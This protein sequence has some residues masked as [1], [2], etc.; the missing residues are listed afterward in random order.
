MQF[1]VNTGIEE[2][3]ILWVSD[4]QPAFSGGLKRALSF[5]HNA[6][7][8][9]MIPQ[10]LASAAQLVSTVLL[11]SSMKISLTAATRAAPK[12]TSSWLEACRSV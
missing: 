5:G 7:D 11:C 4:S 3:Y 2:P 12:N 9:L 10:S 6:L 1:T 8:P